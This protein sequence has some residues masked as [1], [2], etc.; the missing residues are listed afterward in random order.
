M[1]WAKEDNTER[2]RWFAA[3]HRSCCDRVR[4]S[5]AVAIQLL[6]LALQ[7][8]CA[9]PLPALVLRFTNNKWPP[10]SAVGTPCEA[11]T[12]SSRQRQQCDL[13]S[14]SQVSTLF[15]NKAII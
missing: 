13:K 5:G 11:V 14:G 4:V 9:L 7:R 12:Q 8:S 6:P 3:T 10:L 15:L 2:V 1:H